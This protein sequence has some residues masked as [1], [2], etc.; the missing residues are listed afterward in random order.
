[1][2]P[3]PRPMIPTVRTPSGGVR[4]T[5][6][7]SRRWSHRDGVW[8]LRPTV[9][10]VL[11]ATVPA[12]GRVSWALVVEGVTVAHRDHAETTL[13]AIADYAIAYLRG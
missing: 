7:G 5:F 6:N 13:G 12:E 4:R 11:I 9:G 3:T 2:I 8:T 1:M 10:S